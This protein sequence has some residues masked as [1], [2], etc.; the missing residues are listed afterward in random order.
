M[1]CVKKIT[2]VLFVIFCILSCVHANAQT[3]T[4][5]ATNKSIKDILQDI[6]TISSYRF[7]YNSDILQSDRKISVELQKASIK[8]CMTKILGNAYNYTIVGN[9]VVITERKKEIIPTT[10]PKPPVTTKEKIV[11]TYDTIQV[12]EHITVYDTIV[13][14]Q[15]VTDTIQHVKVLTEKRYETNLL[16]TTPHTLTFSFLSGVVNN[17]VHFYSND[18]FSKS[19]Q[20]Q[21][22]NSISFNS[23]LDINYTHNKLLFTTGLNLFNIR[24]SNSYTKTSYK[25][26]PS[27]TYTDTIWYWKYNELFHYY[28]FTEHGDSVVVTAYDSTYTF[29]IKN[30]PKKIENTTSIASINSWYYLAI[31]IG[32]GFHINATNT[33]AIQPIT[34][35]NTMFLIHSNGNIADET[36]TKTIPLSS[37]LKK[38]TFSGS[39]HCNIIYSIEKRLS[40]TMQPNCTFTPSNFKKSTIGTQAFTTMLGIT[41]GLHYTIPYEIR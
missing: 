5:S 9:Q 30:N 1:V 24:L 26:D 7:S 25:D 34:K 6:E 33:L 19:L 32:I 38:V 40:L 13:E 36:C 41:W 15:T 31:P 11:T 20:K 18:D 27:I 29:Q 8:T 2:R 22:A 10:K 3:I 21:H 35:L 17:M 28:K 39:I 4:Y 37:I 16:H 12:V 14:K 23:Q